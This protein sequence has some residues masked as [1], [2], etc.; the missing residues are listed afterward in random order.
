MKDGIFLKE[1]FNDVLRSGRIRFNNK[2][3][4]QWNEGV[5]LKP[6]SAI[7]VDKKLFRYYPSLYIMYNKPRSVVCVIIL[8]FV[9]VQ[10]VL[11]SQK[12]Y[13]AKKNQ[14]SF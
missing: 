9:D 6:G 7:T 8:C 10:F 11:K 14:N 5:K 4:W 12:N 3:I 1:E 13:I 2:I